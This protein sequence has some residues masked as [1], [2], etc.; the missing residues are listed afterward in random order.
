MKKSLLPITLFFSLFLIMGCSNEPS[1]SSPNNN[2]P[3][4]KEFNLTASNWKFEPSIITVNNGDKVI[5]H[6]TSTDVAHG[7]AINEF[8]VSQNLN[9]GETT[10]VEF[11]ANKKGEFLFFC[12]VF[13]GTGHSNMEG[14]LIVK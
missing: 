13:C 14:T 2:S 5:F 4:T 1:S 3:E 10:D 12:N 11:I 9:P 8:G 6:V 7:I